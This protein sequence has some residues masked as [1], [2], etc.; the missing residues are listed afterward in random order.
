LRAGWNLH[1]DRAVNSFDIDLCTQR[2]F[3]HA[4]VLFA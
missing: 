2:C 1:A 4:D 3:D